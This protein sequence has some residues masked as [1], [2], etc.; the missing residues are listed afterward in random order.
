MNEIRKTQNE[1][2]NTKE[3][4]G[5]VY[6]VS[7]IAS[8]VLSQLGFTLIELLVVIAL[9][10]ILSTIGLVNYMDFNRSQVVNQAS[11]KIVQELR[12]AQNMAQTNKKEGTDCDTLKNYSVNFSGNTYTINRLCFSSLPN[13]T[14]TPSLIKTD[15]V[16]AVTL[17]GFTYV[18]FPV[19]RQAPTTIGG[20]TMTVTGYNKT[21]TI[22]VDP[23]G[24]IKI[25]E[26]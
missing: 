24:T 11:K 18:E 22:I 20:N 8:C 17:T 10:G 19:L 2:R 25:V 15:S 23:G 14:P 5:N 12:F 1:K 13:V 3:T 7:R 16:T 9:T 21:R 4:I 6:R 26:E